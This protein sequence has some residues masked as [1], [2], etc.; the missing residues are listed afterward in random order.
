[1]KASDL[2][3]ALDPQ[4]KKASQNAVNK[5]KNNIKKQ[6][7]N[8]MPAKKE[9][10][11]RY[12]KDNS[13][14]GLK[15]LVDMK[16]QKAVVNELDSM[17]FEQNKEKEQRL[18]GNSSEQQTQQK[19]PSPLEVWVATHPE[20]IKNMSMEEIT[21][22]SMLMNSGSSDPLTSLM[23]MGMNKNNGGGENSLQ[24]KL[25]GMVIEKMFNNN[26]GNGKKES[27][28]M[29]IIKM[30]IAQNMKTQEMIMN[31]VIKQNA[32]KPENQNNTFMKE[33]FGM[34]KGQSDQENSML[35]EKLNNLEMRQNQT[36]PLGEAKRMLEYV[37]TFGGA[38][39]G[40]NQT[41]ATM[42][43]ELDIKN[44]D[45]EQ[46][47]LTK[48]EARRESNM[49]QIGGMINNTIETFGKILSEPIAEAAKKKID[50]FTEKASQPPPVQKPRIS[51]EQYQQKIDL[52]DLEN[53]EE[54]LAQYDNPDLTQYNNLPL[55]NQ[56]K[57]KSRFKVSESGK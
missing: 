42:K 22:L 11:I 23:M 16:K 45:F 14:D 29:D 41:P 36:D 2:K 19:P 21:K 33:I 54:D 27:G 43:H 52:G 3:A 35:R 1:M 7:L 12:V 50:Q 5:I 40:G 6:N 55:E 39:G 34:I 4:V 48:E 10:E 38:F 56:P 47:R 28:D 32:P 13:F 49:E 26:E 37:K 9:T 18:K 30:M 44:M 24:T 53:L 8:K 25:L 20:E 15:Q 17:I 57:R 51:P 46:K 31:M